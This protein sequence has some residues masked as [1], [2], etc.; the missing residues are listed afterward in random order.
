MSKFNDENVHTRAIIPLLRYVSIYHKGFKINICEHFLDIARAF[1][2]LRV[3]LKNRAHRTFCTR[4]KA[5]KKRLTCAYWGNLWLDIWVTE[6]VYRVQYELDCWI[7]CWCT[8]T[9]QAFRSMTQ[10]MLFFKHLRALQWSKMNVVI[11]LT[12][13]LQGFKL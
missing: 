2:A 11:N 5:E 3:S 10:V 6:D 8:F 7:E 13:L 12:L 1:A 9:F 4:I